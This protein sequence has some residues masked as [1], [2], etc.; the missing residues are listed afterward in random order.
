MH[1]LALHS[2]NV[3]VSGMVVRRLEPD[4][5]VLEL[6]RRVS[7]PGIVIESIPPEELEIP[8]DVVL[9]SK[10]Q[11]VTCDDITK[12]PEPAANTALEVG[13]GTVT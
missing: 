12:T 3:P 7:D 8:G 6:M 4:D 11:R 10:K 9:K 1:T 5:D 13:V 2:H